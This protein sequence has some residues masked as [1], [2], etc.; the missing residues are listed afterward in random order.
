MLRNGIEGAEVF[1][2]RAM[3]ENGHGRFGVGST[4]DQTG[5]GNGT[6]GKVG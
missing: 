6:W 2:P 5:Y 1:V 3:L 4:H